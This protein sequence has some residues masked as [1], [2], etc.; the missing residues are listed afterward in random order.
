MKRYLKTVK[1]DEA[2]KKVLESV[3]PI[4]GAEP[5]AVY[6]CRGRIT[7][8]TLYA[9]LSNPPF[10][11]AAM[12][13]YAVS[14][15]KTLGADLASPVDL[16]KKGEVI[17]VN[18]GDLLPSGMNAV[19]M[20]EDVEEFPSRIA[21]RKSVYLW[22]NVRMIG[23]DII[24]GDM[25]LPVNHTITAFDIGMIISAGMTHISVR[26]KPRAVI[27][28][29]GRELVDI[30]KG[31]LDTQGEP[32]LI[33]FNSYTLKNMAEELGY[34]VRISE[35]ACDKEALRI[36]VI[37][38]LEKNDVILVNAGTSAGREDYTE[39]I[40]N[41]LGKVVFHG[42]SMMPG[43]PAMFGLIADKPVFGIPGYPVSAAV[44][45]KAFLVPLYE[46][47][48]TVKMYKQNLHCVLAYKTPSRVGIEE[49]IRVNLID[50]NG[51]YFAVPLSRGA[52]L[53]SSMAKADG[54][55]RIPENTE[56]YEEGE[57]VSCELLRSEEEIAGR[58]HIIG[59]HDL[60]L[61]VM[62]DMVKAGYPGR[63]LIST[64]TG[65]LSGIMALK[66]GITPLATTHILDEKEKI[67]NVPAIRRYLPDEA[68]K[69]IHIAKR[70]Q[71]LFVAGG[72][73][74]DIRGLAD[75]IRPDI[76]FV[77]RQFGSG[78]R[79][80]LD[81]M[82]AEEGLEKNTINGYDREESSHTAVGVLVKGSVADVGVGIYSVAKAFS[83][84]FIPLA[85][86]EYDLLVTKKFVDDERFAILMGIVTSG[87]FVSRLNG[88]GGYNTKETGKVKYEQ[89]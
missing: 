82:L 52:S 75:L 50:N 23:E 51:V 67:Y 35:I 71:G 68:V 19:I 56:G 44:T 65:S 2:I 84:D 46:K 70:M 10:L 72:N 27:I 34:E 25:L 78:T 28:P 9:K 66:K 30:F 73:P 81:S 47:F 88:M 16:E 79:I 3:R 6:E 1:P 21:I 32:R 54:I 64:H 26:R 17:P 60:S 61:D 58:I 8:E 39:G 13:G 36:A 18:T 86:E 76:K 42:V 22:Q 31:P 15:E 53:F 33:D 7:A 38:A 48:M 80:L 43:K 24:E 59:S 89:P 62:R 12:D 77:N 11:C 20:V 63:D 49:I 83:L 41:D 55:V 5:L 87:E 40:I 29:T 57:E 74:K 4:E 45:F 37:N 69:L 85:E 14:F